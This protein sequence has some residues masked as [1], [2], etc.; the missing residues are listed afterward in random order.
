VIRLS[1]IIP[2]YNSEKY[3]I[4]CV[5]SLLRQN[6][7]INEYEIIIIDDGSTDSSVALLEDILIDQTNILVYTQKNSGVGSAKNRGISLAKGKYIYFIDPDDYLASDVLK[8]IIDCAEKKE[9][10]VLTFLS[11]KTDSQS[12]KDS[13]SNIAKTSCT[14]ILNGTDY[15]AN[16][17]FKNEVWWYVINRKYLLASGINFIEGRWMED[18]IFTAELI[19]KANKMAHLPID[20]H[21]HVTVKGSA[22]TSREP[23]H[24]KKVIYDNANAAT[25]YHKIIE[26]LEYTDNINKECLQR[27]KTRQ[28]SFVFFMMVRMLK[29]TMKLTEIKKILNE[30]IQVKA[31]PLKS[32]IRI[33][34]NVILYIILVKLFNIKTIFYVLFMMFNPFFKNK[35]I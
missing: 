5:E 32:F 18:A 17:G 27:L 9:L 33:D 30:M 21:R 6:L 23:E 26:T 7:S 16:H 12:L 11:K 14:S 31:Y 35:I 22:M 24:Y 8:T 4:N 28:Q 1:I 34:Y 15:V 29:S 10:D 19:I 20:V 13:F 3:I 2:L 25:A